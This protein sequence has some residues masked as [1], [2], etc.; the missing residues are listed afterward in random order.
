[1][2]LMAC[3]VLHPPSSS[4]LTLAAYKEVTVPV[5]YPALFFLG[6]E[7]YIHKAGTPDG[8]N[9][10]AYLCGRKYSISQQKASNKPSIF[11]KFLF[12]F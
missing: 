4:V 2:G 8:R 6:S 5:Q 11:V 12:F 7:I 3:T 10:L 1:M 9:I